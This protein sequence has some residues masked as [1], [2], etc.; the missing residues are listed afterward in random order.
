[1]SDDEV[2]GSPPVKG[3]PNSAV[4]CFTFG[5]KNS[6]GGPCGANVI[7]GMKG[8]WRHAGKTLAKAKAEGAVRVELEAWGLGDTTVDPGEVLLRL[9]TQSAARCELYGRLLGEA[10]E[11]AERLRQAHLSEDL[12][13]VGAGQFAD[14]DGQESADVQ[15]AR[16]D[17]R[18]IFATGGVGALV[19]YTLAATKDG[20]IYAASEALRGLVRLE[21]EERD[22]CAGFATK[23]VAAGL[24]ERQ[25]RLAERQGEML[26]SVIRLILEDL[27]LSVEQWERVTEIVPRRLRELGGA[28]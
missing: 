23:A 6:R 13:E 1:M 7:K 11:A 22:R 20:D 15:A 19:G 5:H 17:L 27:G 24:A 10:Y 18:R 4:K 21:S 8:C 3:S 16:L 25:V 14:A 2:M 26:A 28:A 12:V 9:V